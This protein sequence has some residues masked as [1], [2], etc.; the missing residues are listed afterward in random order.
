M[1]RDT[2][3]LDAGAMIAFLRKEAGWDLVADAFADADITC[4]A[5]VANLTEVF[6]DFYRVGDEA[7]AQKQIAILYQAGVAP[8][9]DMDSMLWQDAARIKAD[10]RRVSLADCFGLALA[11]RAGTAF[12]STDHH[13]LG[14]IHAAG[15]CPI[16]FIR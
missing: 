7:D 11:R 13:E 15:V 10:Y 6:Y 3:V 14:A 1:S 2:L 4:Y 9:E 16:E 8:C 5:H 12:L